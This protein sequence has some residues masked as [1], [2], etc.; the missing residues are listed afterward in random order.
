MAAAYV[1]AQVD[2]LFGI[3]IDINHR[4]KELDEAWIAY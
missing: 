4:K 1:E 3:L 2:L